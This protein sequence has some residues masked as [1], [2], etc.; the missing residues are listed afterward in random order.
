M[1]FS[2]FLF[3]PRKRL[4]KRRKRSHT[5]ISNTLVARPSTPP[6]QTPHVRFHE[7]KWV[8]TRLSEKDHTQGL[9]RRNRGLPFC[10]HSAALCCQRNPF[11]ST[12]LLYIYISRFSV[13]PHYRQKRKS[14]RRC[15]RNSVPNHSSLRFS[16]SL[17]N[18]P[19]SLS[20]TKASNT[21]GSLRKIAHNGLHGETGGVLGGG[22]Y[23]YPRRA[24]R[25]AETPN[26]RLSKRLICRFLRLPSSTP[27]AVTFSANMQISLSVI[28]VANAFT[29]WYDKSHKSGLFGDEGEPE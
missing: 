26:V 2:C 16:T 1:P 7:R 17:T 27:C 5:N 15:H 3:R 22:W 18:G 24:L 13:A 4:E 6:A 9:T 21:L 8:H 29:L 28:S 12:V 14:Q 19:R 10:D 25:A 20:Q 11:Y 23:H